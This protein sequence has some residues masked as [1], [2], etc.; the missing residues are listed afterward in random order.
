MM[1]EMSPNPSPTRPAAPAVGFKL[2][3]A[4]DDCYI[5]ISD[6]SHA[7][8]RMISGTVE[9]DGMSRPARVAELAILTMT[10][11]DTI[12]FAGIEAERLR[13]FLGRFAAEVPEPS[14]ES[15]ALYR[16]ATG[17]DR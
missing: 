17:A 12:T 1:P 5:N 10:S 16:Q 2:F 6:I 8:F 11:E 14:P 7:S 3:L 4:I 13:I 15:V 9:V